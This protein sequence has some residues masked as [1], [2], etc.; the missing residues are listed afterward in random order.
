MADMAQAATVVGLRLVGLTMMAADPTAL[1]M[2]EAQRMIVEK[3]M[4][5]L[6]GCFAMQMEWFKLM[7]SPPWLWLG[8]LAFTELLGSAGMAPVRRR[9]S[10]NARRLKSRKRL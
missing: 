5:L 7:A 1:R 3:Q 10:A 2:S 8:P 4:A 9:L 6:D